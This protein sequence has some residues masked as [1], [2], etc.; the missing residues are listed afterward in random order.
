MRRARGAAVI[1]TAHPAYLWS[2]HGLGASGQQVMLGKQQVTP[3]PLHYFSSK[4]FPTEGLFDKKVSL[5]RN[6]FIQTFNIATPNFLKVKTAFLFPKGKLR[7]WTHK[8]FGWAGFFFFTHL[9]VTYVPSPFFQ[10]LIFFPLSSPSLPSFSTPKVAEIK[11]ENNRQ[12]QVKTI[13]KQRLSTQ[14]PFKS[15]L[16]QCLRSAGSYR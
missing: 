11:M 16:S 14:E 13:R 9:L 3:S 2:V 8:G 5:N 1:G 12:A 4:N 10:P 15:R 7:D 6:F